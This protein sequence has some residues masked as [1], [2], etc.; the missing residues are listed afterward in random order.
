MKLNRVGEHGKWDVI[1]DYIVRTEVVLYDIGEMLAEVGVLEY[2]GVVIPID[3]AVFEQWG[4][5][6]IGDQQNCCNPKY[7]S[8]G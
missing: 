2:S 6:A 5:R 4:E 8:P 3:E 7:L 1:A